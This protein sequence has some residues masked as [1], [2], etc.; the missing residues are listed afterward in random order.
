MK[1]QHHHLKSNLANEISTSPSNDDDIHNIGI[2]KKIAD[3]INLNK[4]EYKSIDSNEYKLLM[5]L[6]DFSNNFTFDKKQFSEEG[7]K[8]DI[9]N[10][11]YNMWISSGKKLEVQLLKEERN[12][13]LNYLKILHINMMLKKILFLLK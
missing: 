7:L 13:K 4:P 2:D 6:N 10:Y 12:L 3:N 8:T 5:N 11:V 9:A 1:Y